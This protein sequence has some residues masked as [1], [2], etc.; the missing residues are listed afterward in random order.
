MHQK[1]ITWNKKNSYYNIF[2]TFANDGMFSIKK[3]VSRLIITQ[4]IIINNNRENSLIKIYIIDYSLF[5]L[6]K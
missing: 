1:N 5:N 6:L 2:I 4:K 3:Y